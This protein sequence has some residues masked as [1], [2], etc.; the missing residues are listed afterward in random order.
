MLEVVF[1]GVWLLL[2][3]WL[4]VSGWFVDGLWLLLGRLLVPTCADG[5]A[6]LRVGEYVDANFNPD[7]LW[8]SGF[9]YAFF[10]GKD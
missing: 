8:R 6:L 4:V 9:F 10:S 5:T 2:G 3:V 7:L 1:V